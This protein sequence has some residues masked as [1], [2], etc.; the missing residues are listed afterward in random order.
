MDQNNYENMPLDEEMIDKY[1]YE[2]DEQLPKMFKQTPYLSEY[3]RRKW[4]IRHGKHKYIDFDEDQRKKLRTCFNSLAGNKDFIEYQEIIN[5]L[6]ALGLVDDPN[7][8]E[9]L[10]K[11]VDKNDS[12]EIE[13]NEFLAILKSGGVKEGDI[14]AGEIKKFF[15]DYIDKKLIEPKYLKMPFNLYISVKRREAIMNALEIVGNED[16]KVKDT[17][18]FGDDR[19]YR[20]TEDKKQKESKLKGQKVMNAYSKSLKSVKNKTKN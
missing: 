5:P 7:K 9:K 19:K 20:E 12:G 4:L 1:W 15:K 10:I 16:E 17:N 11:I 2:L 8:A 6:I 13:F 18:N 3:E 14:D